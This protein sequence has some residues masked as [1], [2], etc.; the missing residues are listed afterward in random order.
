[1]VNSKEICRCK[2]NWNPY[3]DCCYRELEEIKENKFSDLEL[4][5]MMLFS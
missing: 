4:Y 1:F 5:Q 2:Y 3:Q